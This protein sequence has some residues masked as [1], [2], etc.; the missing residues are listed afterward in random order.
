MI[1]TN[2]RQAS[3]LL[4]TFSVISLLVQSP[5]MG[6]VIFTES[7]G[8][9]G[10]TTTIAAHESANGFDNDGLT[11]SGSGDIRVTTSSTGKYSGASGGANAFLTDNAE[12][13]I[14][15]SGIST[16][17]YTP[18]T[19]DISFGVHKN[20]TASTMATLIL[21]Y[22][23]DTLNWNPIV[24]LAGPTGEGTSVWHALS[25][26]NTIIPI[27]H[28]LSLRWTNSDAST[29]YRIDDVVLSAVP[30]PS[31][32]VLSALGFFGILRRRR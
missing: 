19:V 24:T 28:T 4:L 11:F 6:A 32:A 5:T 29:Q 22:S 31:I 30:E 14:T 25:F 13:Y 3:P 10:E 2:K 8:T 23:T 21:A 26:E 15:I 17:G 12:K 1:T 16:L 7:F 27:S 20:A 18:G 9:V